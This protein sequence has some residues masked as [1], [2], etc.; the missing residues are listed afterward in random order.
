MSSQTLARESADYDDREWGHADAGCAALR[1]HAAARVPATSV[2]V[3]YNWGR[4]QEGAAGSHT[5]RRRYP[6]RQGGR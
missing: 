3:A 6:A 5:D 2:G 4:G 1:P